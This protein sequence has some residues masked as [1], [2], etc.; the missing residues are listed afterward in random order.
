MNR[1]RDHIRRRVILQMVLG[2]VLLGIAG[3]ALGDYEARIDEQQ[4]R[5]ALLDM[6]N[7]ILSIDWIENPRYDPPKDSKD[8]KQPYWPFEVFLRLPRYGES[9]PKDRIYQDKGQGP[10]LARYPGD[11][12]RN[13]FVAAGLTPT[14]DKDKDKDGNPLRGVWKE[15]AFRDHVRG[16]LIDFYRKEL[17]SE[18]SFSAFKPDSFTKL[19]IPN[20]TFDSIAL[21]DFNRPND[22]TSYFELYFNLQ[23]NRQVAIVYQFPESMGKDESIRHAVDWSLKSLDV[24]PSTIFAKRDALNKRKIAARR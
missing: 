8:G 13:V 10:Y 24:N 2:G 11:K 17:K 3:C 21:R 1:A 9:D 15:Q 19:S 4:K 20:A 18:P 12:I 6:E 5:L 7:K 16:A 23:S 22:A 14:D